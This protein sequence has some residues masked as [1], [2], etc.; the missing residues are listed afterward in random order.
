MT[1]KTISS[2]TEWEDRVGYSRAVRV[3]NEVRVSGTTA[4]DEDGNIVGKNDPYGQTEKALKNIETA[5]ES[6]DASLEDVVRT[7]IY[8]TD[9]EDWEA[10][11]D[12]HAAFFEAIRPATSMVEVSRL[13]TPEMLVEIEADAILER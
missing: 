5:L 1:R 12:A 9:I 8:V 2:G 11:G 3:G 13:V 6:A 10:V 7:R 4:T